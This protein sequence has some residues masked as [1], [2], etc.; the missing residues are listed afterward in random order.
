ML[1]VNKMRQIYCYS[2]SKFFKKI[3]DCGMINAINVLDSVDFEYFWKRGDYKLVTLSHGAFGT[4]SEMVIDDEPLTDNH[5]KTV[6][7]KR[8]KSFV[9]KVPVLVNSIWLVDFQMS[10][11]YFSAFIRYLTDIKVCPYL[12]RYI[13][14]HVVEDEYVLFSEKYDMELMKF[15]PQLNSDY[16]I[17]F[18]FQ[19]TYTIYIL[20]VYLGLVHYDTHLRNLMVKKMEPGPSKIISDS[21]CGLYIP[22]MPYELRLIDFGFCTLDLNVSF[23][24]FLRRDLKIAPHNFNKKPSIPEL[25]TTR[26]GEASK[27]LTIEIQYFCI[28]LYQLVHRQSPNHPMLKVIQNFCECMYQQSVDLMHPSLDGAF[29]LRQ[30]DVGV[31]CS[32]ITQPT[33]LIDGLK[34][35]CR[36][37]GEVVDY[38]GKQIFAYKQGVINVNSVETV[39]PR[40][41]KE[42][43]KKYLQYLEQIY[44]LRW[45]ES[46]FFK[47]RYNIFGYMWTFHTFKKTNKKSDN[48]L[49]IYYKNQPYNINNAYLS[50]DENVVFSRNKN[51]SDFHSRNFYC[52]KFLVYNEK[53]IESKGKVNLLIGILNDQ[54]T[55]VYFEISIHDYVIQF[56]KDYN[57]SMLINATNVIGLRIDY[58][59]KIK[60]NKTPLLYI[61]LM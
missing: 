23:D 56:I 52:G 5:N 31:I 46:S 6:V 50:V 14:L 40:V 24:D 8:N 2:L 58:E 36:K 43:S 3:L 25:F 26:K 34:R 41:S 61:N 27:L 35:Y 29:I 53:Y 1:V 39:S 45:Y 19:F 33:H 21:Y 18:L 49:I 20:K 11:I 54:L 10:E 28:H 12:Q 13:S 32:S 9:T 59:S 4:I 60:I 22:Y 15:F 48:D 7:V 38:D 16:V 30:H 37:Y 42:K 57:F 55:I 51:S 47:F 44:D 17:Q